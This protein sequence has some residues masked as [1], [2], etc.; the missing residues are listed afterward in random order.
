MMDVQDVIHI[1]HILIEKFGGSHGVR[2][3]GALEAAVH[4]PFTTFDKQELYP[5]AVE[6]AA[7]IF[8]SIL[9]NHPF[10]DG[11]KRT[12][13]VMMRL[14]LM[15]HGFDIQAAQDDKYAMVMSASMGEIRFDD[16]KDWVQSRMRNKKDQ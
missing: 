12:A 6:K 10:I 11:N 5:T 3:L 2:D 15:V 9:I 4:R 13:Y 1:H 14:I 7:A 8:E 16:I